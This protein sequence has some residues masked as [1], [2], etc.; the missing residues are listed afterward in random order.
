[1]NFTQPTLCPQVALKHSAPQHTTAP[2]STSGGAGARTCL[3]VINP[4]IS[5]GAG[6]PPK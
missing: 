2:A 6:A 4:P 1:V 3:H 5:G